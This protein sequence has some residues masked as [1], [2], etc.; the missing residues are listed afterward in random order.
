MAVMRLSRWQ[1]LEEVE[2]VNGAKNTC[3]IPCDIQEMM[4]FTAVGRIQV[5]K[6]KL[7]NI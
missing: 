1:G 4:M 7:D 6:M 5:T 2:D 3:C